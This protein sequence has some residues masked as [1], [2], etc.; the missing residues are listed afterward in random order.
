MDSI[1]QRERGIYILGAEG[2]LLHS[3]SKSFIIIWEGVFPRKWFDVRRRGDSCRCRKSTAN[4]NQ[5]CVSEGRKDGD[6]V[7]LVSPLRSSVRRITKSDVSIKDCFS[8]R[9]TLIET[10]DLKCSRVGK[11]WTASLYH[12]PHTGCAGI[13][14]NTSI[15]TGNPFSQMPCSKEECKSLYHRHFFFVR[16]FGKGI[17]SPSLM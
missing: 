14:P 13:P 10:R 4:N 2:C 5:V 17:I 7:T 8:L 1:H 11:A 9:Q 16:N 12:W 3:P 6:T 15:H